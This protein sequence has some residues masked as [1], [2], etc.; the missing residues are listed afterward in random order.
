MILTKAQQILSQ[1]KK[2]ITM[3]QTQAKYSPV[4][5][6]KGIALVEKDGDIRTSWKG[7]T[8]FTDGNIHLWMKCEDDNKDE[9][10]TRIILPSDG[11]SAEA[12]A[13][14]FI[15]EM[16]EYEREQYLNYVE[17][18]EALDATA[19]QLAAAKERCKNIE[20]IFD[21]GQ[22]VFV[23]IDKPYGQGKSINF[24]FPS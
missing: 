20:D 17:A 15:D 19:D 9:H 22:G 11:Y 23:Q 14:D 21:E 1:D 10:L 18:F 12:N 4:A 6:Y 13:K 7:T 16:N 3:T 8:Y 5:E 24:S 2:E